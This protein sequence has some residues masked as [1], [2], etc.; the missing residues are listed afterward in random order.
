MVVLVVACAVVSKKSKII[1]DQQTTIL[2]GPVM[3]D[4]IV[5]DAPFE[6]E[7]CSAHR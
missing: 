4:K 3:Y 6:T 1:R 5:N 7:L 2:A